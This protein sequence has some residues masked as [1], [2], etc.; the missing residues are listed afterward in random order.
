MGATASTGPWWLR[1][2][3]AVGGESWM[4]PVCTC[5]GGA[6][7]IISTNKHVLQLISFS[8]GPLL[9]QQLGEGWSR[10]KEPWEQQGRAELLRGPL[11]RVLR[12]L[13]TCHPP[14]GGSGS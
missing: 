5:G 12:E 8:P 7:K 10:A 14:A 9:L 1:L 6:A 2:T 3:E 4:V 13:W 11:Q